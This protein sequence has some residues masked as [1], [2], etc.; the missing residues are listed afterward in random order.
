M[1]RGRF[2]TPLFIVGCGR[3][4]TTIIYDLICNHPDLAW[5]SNYMDRAPGLPPVACLSRLR[6]LRSVRASSSRYAPRPVEGYAIW[7][8][9]SVP[10]RARRNAWLTE[11]DLDPR[12]LRQLHRLVNACMRWGGRRRFVNKNTRNSR[13]I[14]YLHAAFPDARFVHVMR[15]P[16]AVV[17]SL[18]NVHWWADLPLWW[19]DDQTPRQLVNAGRADVSVAAEH[20][21]RSVSRI[22]ED[23]GGLPPEWYLDVRYEEFAAQPESVLDEIQRFGELESSREVQ[24]A[25]AWTRIG[26]TNYKYR[27]RFDVAELRAIAEIT[28]PVATRLGYDL[29]G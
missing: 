18:L 4:G 5:F 13:R 9:W 27:E 28:R 8:R 1:T 20:W 6:R 15:D 24:Q 21:V 23:L 25:L 2:Q 10:D 12:Q 19:C 29:G 14:R 16:R 22:L 3:S 7:D 11:S 17:A 26:S